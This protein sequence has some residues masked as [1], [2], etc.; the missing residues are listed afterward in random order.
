ML[1]GGL[2]CCCLADVAFSQLTIDN[3][4]NVCFGGKKSICFLSF[5]KVRR[6]INETSPRNVPPHLQLHAAFHAAE[7]C[8][9][10]TR[11][12]F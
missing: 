10:S 12:S 6:S 4:D 9:I 1:R 7:D 2:F 11:L 5:V 8:V 3:T